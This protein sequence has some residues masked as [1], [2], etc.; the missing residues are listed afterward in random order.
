MSF[1]SLFFN[2]IIKQRRFGTDIK[3]NMRFKTT[4]F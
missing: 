3:I 2:P 4:A 1:G